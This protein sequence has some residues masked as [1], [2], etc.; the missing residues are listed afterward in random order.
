MDWFKWLLYICHDMRN[1]YLLRI[2]YTF[3]LQ[4]LKNR[5]TYNLQTRAQ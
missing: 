2:Y 4:Q 1:Q 5:N 3:I